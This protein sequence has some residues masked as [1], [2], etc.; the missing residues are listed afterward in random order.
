[1]FPAVLDP[2]SE[3]RLSAVTRRASL[4]AAG[5]IERGGDNVNS[6]FVSHPRLPVLAAN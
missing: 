4:L 5:C 3:R 1:M 2:F 6:L